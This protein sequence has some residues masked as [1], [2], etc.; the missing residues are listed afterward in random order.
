MVLKIPFT[1]CRPFQIACNAYNFVKISI[2]TLLL[3]RSCYDA[4]TKAEFPPTDV[5]YSHGQKT[6]QTKHTVTNWAFFFLKFTL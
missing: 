5:K 6:L 2:Q 3:H 4:L 1:F